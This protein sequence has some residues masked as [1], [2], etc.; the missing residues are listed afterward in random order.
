MGKS[1]SN[2]KFYTI[3]YSLDIDYFESGAPKFECCSGRG[4]KYN[5]IVAL[6]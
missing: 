6:D 4:T 1:S 3:F 5:I 2:F